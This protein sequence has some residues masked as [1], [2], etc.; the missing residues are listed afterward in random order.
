MKPVSI[1]ASGLST[2]IAAV[3]LSSVF[4]LAGLC[5]GQTTQPAQT[6]VALQRTATVLAVK[7]AVRHRHNRSAKW[8]RTKVGDTL[9]PPAEISTG[10]RNSAAKLKLHTTAVIRIGSTTTIAITELAR[11]KDAEKVRLLL[12]RG[13]VRAGIVEEKVRSDFQIACPAAVLSREGTWG[14]EMR[15]DPATGKYYVGLDT[16]GLLRLIDRLTGRQV[17]VRPGQY[18]TQ[19][20]VRW[21]DTASLDRMVA[22]SDPFGLTKVEKLFNANNPGGLAGADPTGSR[23]W[24]QATGAG[25]AAVRMANQITQPMTNIPPTDDTPRLYRFGNFG[26]YIRD[27]STAQ[28]KPRPHR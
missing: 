22:L 3:G 16:D 24:R 14:M 1:K 6:Q 12:T 9:K 17:R 20:L 15:Y 21:I 13:S 8:V 27:N 5:R 28:P 10:I 25:R 2:T 7:G 18:F 4:I 26:T 11:L 19:A 23:T